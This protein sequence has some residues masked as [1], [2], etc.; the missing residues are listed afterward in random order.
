MMKRILL[1]LLLVVMGMLAFLGIITSAQKSSARR[2]LN[3]YKTQ[4]KAQGEKLSYADLGYPRPPLTNDSLPQLLAAVERLKQ[5]SFQPS[6]LALMELTT[7]GSARLNWAGDRPR[8]STNASATVAAMEWPEFTAIFQ[9][10]EPELAEIRAGLR[11][12]AR[13]WL[14]V[15]PASVFNYPVSPNVSKRTMAHWLSGDLISALHEKQ[16]ARA[17][18]DLQALTQ[19][20]E[21]HREEP[22]LVNQAFRIVIAG[23]VLAD[24]WEALGAA[25]WTEP[26]LATLQG[27]LE[28]LDLLEAIGIGMSS[29]RVLGE[30]FMVELRMANSQQG[31]NLLGVAS[32]G[33][34]SLRGYFNNWVVLPFWRLNMDA[35]ELLYLQ[36]YQKCLDLTRDLARGAAWPVVSSELVNQFNHVDNVT[37][38]QLAR[39]RY[40]FTVMAMPILQRTMQRT[41]CVETQRRLTV[42]AIA[43]ERYRLRH[44]QY[45]AALSALAPEWLA[46]V[47]IDL[48]DAQPLKYRLNPDGSYALYSVGED[49]RDDGGDPQ[50]P[51]GIKATDIWSGRD[52]VWPKVSSAF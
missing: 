34:Q 27:D 39:I 8:F 33:Q 24:A 22:T 36:H 21:L 49:G 5:I 23:L 50:P 18:A 6:L 30:E 11:Q 41:V 17:Q 12:P 7:P 46:A 3:D 38:G 40:M 26:S 9:Q 52:A 29:D 47:P 15:P 42:T 43:L 2:A 4:L 31:Q 48:M 28:K 19:L 44:G 10:A 32:S 45:P 37:S 13:Y 16:L 14:T 51:P 20:V 25:G 35:D 1:L